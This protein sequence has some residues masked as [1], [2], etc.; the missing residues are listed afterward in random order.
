MALV[1]AQQQE[2]ERQLDRLRDNLTSEQLLWASGYMAGLAAAGSSVAHGAVDQMAQPAAEPGAAETLTIWY[3]TETGNARGVARRLADTARERGWEVSLAGLDEVQPRRIGKASLLILVVATHGEGDPPETAEAFCRFIHS[4]RAPSLDK[5]RYAVFAL[6]D[7]SYPDFCQTG[8]ELDERLAELGGERLLDRVDCDVD[9]E[10]QEDPWRDRVVERVEPLMQQG[11]AAAEPHL[12]VVGR[13]APQ[14]ASATAAHDRRNPFEAELLEVSPLTVTPSNKRVAHVELSLEDS[15]IVWQP[16]D[17]LGM[18]PENDP[19]LVERIVEA[20]GVDA[21]AEIEH[22]GRRISLGRWLGRHAELTQVVRPFL[23]RWAELTEAGELQALLDDR[24]ALTR[25][26]AERQVIDVLEDYPLR[27]DAETL[28]GSLRRLAPRLYSI[29]SSPLTVEDEIG[30]TV[31]LE[32]HGA[33]LA[34]RLG[35]ASGQLLERAAPGDVV[36]IYIEPNERFRLPSDGDRPI[37]MIGPGTGVA[38]FRAFVEHRQAQAA[39]GSSWLFFGEQHRRTDFLYQLEWQ[40][41]LRDGALSRLSV[42]FS[43][44][45]AEKVYVQH[46]LREQAREVYAWLEEG[47]HVYVCGSGQGMAAD[48]HQALVDVIVEQAGRSAEQAEE[49]LA[50]MKA[51]HRYQKDVY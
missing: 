48:V 6:G 21:S 24:D 49:Y 26:V 31:K 18:W 35:V 38:P 27:V 8:R 44:D 39:A 5:L 15:G 9:F 51:D 37:I 47:A 1:P 36:P 25:W 2:I 19:A 22:D 50:A 4:D 17:S 29:A 7:S 42:A 20:C 28:A 33:D 3:G 12:Q 34:R 30:L 41:F 13:P 16:G 11:S 10:T 45:Q 40:R 23:V 32:Q 14:A 46:R 43:R